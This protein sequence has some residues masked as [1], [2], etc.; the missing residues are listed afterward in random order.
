LTSFFLKTHYDAAVAIANP[1][2]RKY[3]GIFGQ[4]LDADK[5]KGYDANKDVEAVD[6]GVPDCKNRFLSINLMS[7]TT[8]KVP[9]TS[10]IVT[11]KSYVNTVRDVTAP[12]VPSVPAGPS[13]DPTRDAAQYLAA[14]AAAA[15]SLAA[16]T[17]Y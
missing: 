15:A 16:L 5:G 9:L 17:L 11:V 4:G 13:A 10:N 8:T 14:G 1:F 2:N 12:V 6:G 7:E 3:F